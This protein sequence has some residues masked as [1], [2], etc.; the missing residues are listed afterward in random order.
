MKDLL[1]VR[2]E[3][4]VR[5]QALAAIRGQVFDQPAARDVVII[6]MLR[7]PSP[8]LRASCAEALAPVA[9]AHTPTQRLILHAMRTE[10]DDSVVAE[11]ATLSQ[12][13]VGLSRKECIETWLELV[14]SDATPSQSADHVA[15]LLAEEGDVPNLDLA[16][17]KCLQQEALASGK[18]HACA[19]SLLRVVPKE[20]RKAIVAKYLERVQ[21]WEQGE[22]NTFGAVRDHLVGHGGKVDPATAELYLSIA[23][24]RSGGQVRDDALFVAMRHEKPTP[25]IIERVLKIAHEPKLTNQAMRAIDELV[26]SSPELTPMTIGALEQLQQRASTFVRQSY[27]GDPREEIKKTIERL[28]QAADR[29]R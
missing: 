23:E 17:A 14:A 10:I 24:R 20:R 21:V 27:G 9:R 11:L 3:D 13:F 8:K 18:T 2:N 5:H 25:A 6:C 22:A 26:R 4:H 29:R 7:D 28:K 1:D 16:I 12:G 15:R 19:D